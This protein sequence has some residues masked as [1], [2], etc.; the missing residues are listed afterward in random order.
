MACIVSGFPSKIAALQFEDP[1]ELPQHIKVIQDVKS[2]DQPVATS[3]VALIETVGKRRKAEPLSFGSVKNID[4]TYAG[5]KSHLD[6]TVAMQASQIIRRCAVCKESLHLQGS[7]VLTCPVEGCYAIS[8]VI[9]LAQ[10]F[11]GCQGFEV[12]PTSGHCP[13]CNSEFLWVDLVKELSLRA[14][15]NQVIPRVNKQ[16]SVRKPRGVQHAE[17][18][19]VANAKEQ[20]GKISAL[21]AGSAN[22]TMAFEPSSIDIEDDPLPDDWLQL[23]NDDDDRSVTSHESEGSSRHGSPRILAKQPLK[24][25]IVIE[26]SEWDSA[27]ALD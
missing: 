10:R 5:L 24:L 3:Q 12:L 20:A 11:L 17:L 21:A 14:R 22:T 16:T 27:E 25:P 19:D 2:P 9:C 1:G 4:V 23:V 18:D 6:K 8:H 7:M 15:G 13:D 26:D